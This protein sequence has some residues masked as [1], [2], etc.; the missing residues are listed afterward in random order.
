[1]YCLPF[2]FPIHPRSSE[3]NESACKLAYKPILIL[4][5]MSEYVIMRSTACKN[6]NSLD[7]HGTGTIHYLYATR[8]T[9]SECDTKTEKYQNKRNFKEK[10]V[11]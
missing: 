3:E 11:F 1:M 4:G 8:L 2:L 9:S 5:A 6:N 10:H 7:K